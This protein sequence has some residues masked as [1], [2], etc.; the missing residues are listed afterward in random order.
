[1]AEMS[2]LCLILWGAVSCG[3]LLA[4]IRWYLPVLHRCM[5]RRSALPAGARQDSDSQ[6]TGLP[7]KWSILLVVCTVMLA[8]LCGYR[9]TGSADLLSNLKLL[10]GFCT[11]AVVTATDLT[12]MMIS[13]EVVLCLPV[14]RLLF[15]AVELAIREENLL[16]RLVSSCEGAVF[17]FVVLLI[18]S[19][20]TKGG[21]G[22]GD[23]KLLSGLGFLIGLYA[24]IYTLVLSCFATLVVS[25]GLLLTKK[26]TMKD[27]IPMG[28]CIFVG[29]ILMILL[30]AY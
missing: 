25:V 24:V 21:L 16:P 3:V 22:F 1:M 10:V 20:I 14:S 12:A 29:Y 28:P 18:V 27:A 30:A 13:N 26:K 19:K 23:V 5:E 4:A 6:G 17:C 11:L 2:F 8:C 15:L 7:G 9:T